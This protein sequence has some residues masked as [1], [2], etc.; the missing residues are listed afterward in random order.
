MSH[1]QT[2]NTSATATTKRLTPRASP[3]ER[4]WRQP[5]PS[6]HIQALVQ[7][8]DR[9][10]MIC[11]FN[12]PSCPGCKE[13]TTDEHR[14]QLARRRT[15]DIQAD[16]HHFFALA[17]Q[18]SIVSLKSPAIVRVQMQAELIS[19][20]LPKDIKFPDF[21]V[22]KDMI[23]V[24]PAGQALKLG[25]DALC[26]TQLGTSRGDKKLLMEGADIYR[27]ALQCLRS[28]VS[29]PNAHT[30]DAV[31]GAVYILAVCELFTSI[32]QDGVG[33]S[34][35]VRGLNYLL[36]ARHEQSAESDLLTLVLR[37]YRQF[38]SQLGLITRKRLKLFSFPAWQRVSTSIPSTLPGLA[39]IAT[40]VARALDDTDALVQGQ[41]TVEDLVVLLIR[42]RGLERDMQIWLAWWYRTIPDMP[43]RLM[44]AETSGLPEF[45]ALSE[46]GD[47]STRA[48]FSHFFEFPNFATA[49]VHGVYFAYL[50]QIRQGTR[51]AARALP[52]PASAV[53]P[54][55]TEKLLAEQ[56]TEG[57]DSLCKSLPFI[58]RA[59]HGAAAV[60]RVV[61]GLYLASRWYGQSE[62]S[63]KWLWC[64]K[65]G[66]TIEERGFTVAGLR[67]DG[68]LARYP[69]SPRTTS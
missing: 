36:H 61:P 40:L 23:G 11:P 60:M 22:L 41:P 57:A 24:M 27:K 31:L 52:A 49:Y 30:Q 56:V 28:D 38:A 68:P 32:S 15:L 2:H 13:A 3:L 59:E 48:T 62:Q 10:S 42:L 46:D 35:H 7:D 6:A 4:K 53:D 34:A 20:Y 16:K 58:L 29:R 5:H 55:L 47:D 63:T 26:L 33:W 43:Y 19:L 17:R 54:T 45:A 65:V 12:I 39:D 21:V 44:R 9:P 8:P 66:Q 18:A 69:T 25:M 1:L 51:D 37:G 50:I 64:R 14:A 67:G